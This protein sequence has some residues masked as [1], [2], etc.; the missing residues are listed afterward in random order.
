MKHDE[1][2]F[3]LFLIEFW[4]DFNCVGYRIIDLN[5]YLDIYNLSS[6]CMLKDCFPEN[7]VCT[8]GLNHIEE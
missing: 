1:L 8:Y 5:D 2:I 6:F 3:N 4:K 7:E